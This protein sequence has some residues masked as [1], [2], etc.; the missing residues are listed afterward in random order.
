MSKLFMAFPRTWVVTFG[1]L[2]STTSCNHFLEFHIEI[3][4][5]PYTFNHKASIIKPCL[6][7]FA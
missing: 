4:I 7:M 2:S 3:K 5:H 1:G 6:A